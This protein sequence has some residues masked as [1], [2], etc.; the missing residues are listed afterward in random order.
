MHR[1]LLALKDQNDL[2]DYPDRLPALE[3]TA[4]CTHVQP[5]RS[6]CCCAALAAQ[7]TRSTK[8]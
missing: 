8:Y 6:S 3:S 7:H 2:H 4:L 1:Q 5:S